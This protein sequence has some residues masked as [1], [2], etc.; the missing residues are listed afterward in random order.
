MAEVLNNFFS[1]VHI[2][3]GKAEDVPQAGAMEQKKN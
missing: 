1:L 3:M 2:H